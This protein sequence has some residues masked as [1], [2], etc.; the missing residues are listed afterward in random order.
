M[1]TWGLTSAGLLLLV[2]GLFAWRESQH[3]DLVQAMERERVKAETVLDRTKAE[4]E[5]AREKASELEKGLAD[6]GIEHQ[7]LTDRVANLEAQRDHLRTEARRQASLRKEALAAL[8]KRQEALQEA[9][10][11]ILEANRLP[12]EL[13]GRLEQARTRIRTLEA[14]LDDHTSRG[15]RM[16]SLMEVEGLSTDGRVFALSGTWKPA[17]EM[18]LPVL[19]CRRDRILLNGWLHRIEEGRL[20]GHVA[21]WEEPSSALVKGEKVFILPQLRHEADQH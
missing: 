10:R 9:R 3:L 5:S 19:V 6:L 13:R 17:R 12:R 2:I 14:A 8:G 11:E 1:R 7:S 4:R 15:P 16:P 20:I 21:N 18:P